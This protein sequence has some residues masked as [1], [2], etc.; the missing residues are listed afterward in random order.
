MLKKLS[1]AGLRIS[2]ALL[3]LFWG[4]VRLGKPEV[5]AHVS[6]KYYGGVGAIAWV[7]TGWGLILLSIGLLAALGLWRKFSLPA[8]AIV[9]V[10]GALSIW[11]YL[12]DPLGLWLL[13]REDAQILFFPSLAMAFGSL[14]LVALRQEDQWSLDSWLMRRREA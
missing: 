14:L 7:Q 5:G 8:Q 6:V 11:K 1:L 4:L 2:T 10:T 3:L 13:A 12:L 9:L